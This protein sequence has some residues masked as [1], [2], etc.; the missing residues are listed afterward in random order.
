MK[1]KV[2]DHVRITIAYPA[3][4]L[5]GQTGH[6]ADSPDKQHLNEY[7]VLLDGDN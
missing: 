5:Q 4:T 7:F 2:G 6:I 3:P 1:F